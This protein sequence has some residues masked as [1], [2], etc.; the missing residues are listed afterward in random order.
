M[1]VVEKFIVIVSGIAIA[2]GFGYFARRVGWLKEEQA[3]PLMFWTVIFGWTPASMLVLWQLPLVWSLISLPILSAILPIALYPFGASLSKLH[4]LEPKSAGTFITACGISNIGF[5]MGGFVCYVLFGMAGLGYANLF[6][7]SW[8]VPYVLFYYPMARRMGEE[9]KPLTLGF[10]LKT[11]FD[12]R[13][14]PILGSIVGLIL[15]LSKMHIP[16]S[17]THLHI[18]DILIIASILISFAI[19]GLQIHF[20]SLSNNKMLHASLGL[21]KYVISPILMLFFLFLSECVF[22]KLPDTGRTVVLVQS[23]MP[24]AIFTVIIS[25]LF[26]L[27]PRLASILFLVNTFIFLGIVLPIIIFVIL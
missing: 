24:T 15:N 21:A 10:L 9:N 17:V 8:A 11:F 27:N 25:N 22:G 3:S 6:A 12:A 26:H 2:M 7:S 4:K 13:S 16:E 18:I 20:S 23:F 5:T 1:T 14:L 19:I